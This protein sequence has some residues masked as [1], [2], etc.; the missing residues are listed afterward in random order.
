MVVCRSQIHFNIGMGV[1]VTVEGEAVVHMA[2]EGTF[3][4]NFVAREVVVF[5]VFWVQL[6]SSFIF[7][8]FQT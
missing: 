3:R 1:V 6:C 5:S 2:T 4:P 7:Y 8:C